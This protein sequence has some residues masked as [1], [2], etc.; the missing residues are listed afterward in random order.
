MKKLLACISCSL[1][2]AAC[3]ISDRSEHAS[4]AHSRASEDARASVAAPEVQFEVRDYISGKLGAGAPIRI[5]NPWGDIRVRKTGR[6]GV[7]EITAAIQRI[8]PD[9][10]GQP[11]LRTDHSDERFSASV[12]FP[13]GQVANGTRNARVDLMVMVPAGHPM[14]FET[15]DGAIKAKKTAGPVVARSRS[16][17]ITIINDGSIRA[18]S[19]SGRVQVRPMFPRWGEVELSSATGKVVAFLPESASFEIRITG[20]DRVDSDWSLVRADSGLHFSTAE[21]GQVLDSVKIDSA[22]AVEL[23]RAAVEPDDRIA[24]AESTRKGNKRPR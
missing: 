21:D 5:E 24:D 7:V 4:G 19:E 18:S 12:E 9:W 16:G 11:E 13:G 23:Y 17:A 2:A 22:V 10:P 15:L 3:A 1:L 14:D 6:T 8:G 20:V